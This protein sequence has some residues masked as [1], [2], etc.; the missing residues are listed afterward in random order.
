LENLETRKKGC[1][2]ERKEGGGGN[3]EENLHQEEKGENPILNKR[4]SATRREKG[5]VSVRKEKA[6]V[7]RGGIISVGNLKG[8][9]RKPTIDLRVD[10]D[11]FEGKEKRKKK[12]PRRR[13]E[14]GV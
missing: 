10:F 1:H 14:K 11:R 9:G 3:F 13:K 4:R 7:S 2:E 6:Y 12:T 8:G 5:P